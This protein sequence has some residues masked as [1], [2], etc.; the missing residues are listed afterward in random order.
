MQYQRSR[1][2]CR[3]V[4]GFTVWV[5]QAPFALAAG[6]VANAETL[7]TGDVVSGPLAYGR[8]TFVLPSGSW[9]LIA[10]RERDPSSGGPSGGLLWTAEFDEVVD[11]RLS[12]TLELVATK[13]SK[14]FNW[15]DEPCKN[16][17]DSYWI[18]DRKRG[19][20]DQFCIRV[21]FKSGVVEG[22]RGDAFEAWARDLTAKNVGYS[23]EMPFVRVTRY[24]AYDFLQMTVAVDPEGWGVARSKRAERPFNDWNPK[25]LAD[26][27][28]QQ[29]IYDA[30]KA[31][32]DKFSPAVDR[33]FAGDKS[34]SGEDYGAPAFP[35][36][37]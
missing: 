4:L 6:E 12:R 13:Y 11:K 19:L 21:G 28:D 17:G 3:V 14:S 23:R 15:V 25:T 37:R 30:L 18:D 35:R 5:L 34:L 7:R 31:W 10:A 33:A 20:N 22:A 27:P 16:K 24:N 29:A 26:H 1:N 32:A 36:K 2:V 9:R 8:R